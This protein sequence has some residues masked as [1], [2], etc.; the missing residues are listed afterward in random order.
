MNQELLDGIRYIMTNMEDAVCLT[1]IGG[2][3]IYA[4]PAAKK[5]FGIS[6]DFE[7]L[8]EE[9]EEGPSVEHSAR[10]WDAIPFVEGNDALIQL[11]IDGVMEKKESLHSM[12]QYVNNEGALF[13]L[14]VTLTASEDSGRILI[15]IHDITELTK[16]SSA[17]RRYTS[18]EIADYVLTT[19][20]GEKQ[21]GTTREVSILMSDLRGFTA[22][23][24]RFSPDSLILMLNHYLEIMTETINRFHGT[25]IE[26]LGDGIFVTFGAPNDM[27]DHAEAAVSCAVEMQNAMARVN[28][29]NRDHG[30]PDLEMGIAISSGPAVVGNIGS[31]QKMK[32]GCMG[33]SVNLAGRLQSLCLG[34]E[35]FVAESTRRLISGRL[36][37]LEEKTFMPK[38]A[39]E[40]MKYYRVAGI[41]DYL[42]Q[43]ADEEITWRSLPAPVDVL[44]FVL[45]GKAVESESHPGRLTEVSQDERFAVLASEV[46]LQPLQ[47][48]MLRVGSLE[49][50]ANVLQCGSGS[51]RIGFTAR[52]EDFS[53]F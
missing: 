49:F 17:F 20:E 39:R 45:D 43:G 48:L 31:D 36:D 9:Y 53:F 27:P 33:E 34:R 30:F 12:V 42:L 46:P 26:F 38:G 4:N 51:C 23:S 47:H 7:G 19:P 3:L 5:L 37:I 52:P 22:L 35:I 44:F 29:W 41:G 2:E 28:E 13:H 24:T 16:V 11:F 25:V 50:Y 14:H 10:I 1:G 40:T 21:G 15:V 8:S 6:G 18:P 32:Y